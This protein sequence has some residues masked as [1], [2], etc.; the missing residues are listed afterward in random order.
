M[1]SRFWGVFWIDASSHQNVERAYEDI[2]ATC[3][4]DQNTQ[5]TKRWLSNAEDPWLLIIDNAD[6]PSL[7]I[8]SY[9]PPGNRG[10]VLLT[11]RNPDCRAHATVG[12][13]HSGAMSDDDA[14]A[15][16]LKVAAIEDLSESSRKAARSVAETLG[17]LALALVQAGAFI[18]QGFCALEEYCDEYSRQ[19]QE[20][21][22]YQTVQG[23][24]DYPFTVHTTLEVSITQ[25]QSMPSQAADLA[26]LLLHCFSF[27]HFEGIPRKLFKE[28]WVSHTTTV[29]EGLDK[30][31]P[32]F[33]YLR[34]VQ[35]TPGLFEEA[36]VLLT[37]FSLISAAPGDK[38]ISMHP[39]VHTWACGRLQNEL[40]SFCWK[41]AME[42]LAS[43]LHS[44][45]CRVEWALSGE[46]SRFLLPHVKQC[47]ELSE[48]NYWDP[49]MFTFVHAFSLSYHMYSRWEEMRQLNQMWLDENKC[50]LGDGHDDV[51]SAMR[52]LALAY[53]R[54]GLDQR[55]LE[56]S[57]QVL[58]MRLLKLDLEHQDVLESMS[59]VAKHLPLDRVQEAI[60]LSKEILEVNRKNLGNEHETT[61]DSMSNLAHCYKK[62]DLAQDALEL[63]SQVLRTREKTRVAKDYQTLLSLKHVAD[64]YRHLGKTQDALTLYE[65]M[66]DKEE[67]FLSIGSILV[68]QIRY[69]MAECRYGLGQKQDAVQQLEQLLS[70]CK[71]M[72]GEKHI[73]THMM[74]KTLADWNSYQETVQDTSQ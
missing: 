44:Q 19:R 27:W 63:H 60:K 57:E 21:L 50:I 26:L 38:A 35:G 17:F 34:S 52:L 33:P 10:T 55:A 28:A 18:R 23:G 36:V 74:A 30:S 53:R 70:S 9:F 54:L 48:S 24:S 49:E 61:L 3:G 59:D 5:Q 67:S 11:T 12:S 16:L 65:R 41:L 7:D 71:E 56:L 39:L 20:L 15:L 68:I 13:F 8:S 51:L 45:T 72:F 4:L 47:V 22:S 58:R 66:I 62:A 40:R 2:G 64:C 32:D 73:M 29:S 42:T 6:D 69:R 31:T 37:S 25:I 1:V 43:V 14:I 46:G